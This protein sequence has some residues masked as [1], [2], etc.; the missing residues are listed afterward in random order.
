MEPWC[1]LRWTLCDLVFEDRWSLYKLYLG[2][3]I[4]R[5]NLNH[6]KPCLVVQIEP[7]FIRSCR[8][9]RLMLIYKWVLGGAA[10]AR[11]RSSR[12][13]AQQLSTPGGGTDENRW[14]PTCVKSVVMVSKGMTNE[15]GYFKVILERHTKTKRRLAIYIN[16]VNDKTFCYNICKNVLTYSIN[17]SSCIYFLTLFNRFLFHAC[18]SYYRPCKI[19]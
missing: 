15:Q 18:E 6:V 19:I 10:V 12:Q 7:C 3:I 5:N 13:G 4:S 17:Y 1:S 9:F 11:G 16:C 14:I 2:A 8:G